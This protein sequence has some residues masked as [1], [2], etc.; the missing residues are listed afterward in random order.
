MRDQEDIRRDIALLDRMSV[1]D[2]TALGELYDRHSRLLFGLILRIVQQRGEAEDVLQEVFVQAWTHADRYNPVLGSPVGWLIGIARNRA[3]D[4][5]RS[6][7]VRTR[8]EE[9]A[10][11]A[12]PVET[13]EAH[14]SFSELQRD[15]RYALSSLPAD[16]RELIEQAYFEGLTQ[17]ELAARFRI[18]LGTV[19]TR[20]RS[21]L[22]GLRALLQRSVIEL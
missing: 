16:Q 6:N 17:S 4:R 21:G 11:P 1:R 3:V 14:T 8:A 20:V 9:R 5:V 7:A 12:P 19:K 10:T 2:Q 15:I 18:P 22:L 13:P